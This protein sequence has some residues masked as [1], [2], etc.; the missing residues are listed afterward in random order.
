MPPRPP[1]PK[2]VVLVVDD[3][4]GIRDVFALGLGQDFEVECARSANEAELMLATREYDVIVCDHL[5]PDEEG[6]AFLTRAR[7]QFPR[8]Q[9]ILMT[10]YM[11]ADLLSRSTALAGLAACLTKPVSVPDMIAAVRHALPR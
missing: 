4:A 11:N 2:P 1:P 5:M 9:R 10:G 8:V 3:E 7:T 6:L